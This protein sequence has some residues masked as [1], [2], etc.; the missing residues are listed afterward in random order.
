MLDSA[1]KSLSSFTFA[2]PTRKTLAPREK[3]IPEVFAT[4]CWFNELQ[5]HLGVSTVVAVQQ[6]A[7]P[8]TPERAAALSRRWRAY[9][10]GEQRPS[11]STVTLA[12]RIPCNAKAILHSP[13]WDALRMDK[14]PDPIARTLLG[15]TC[16][17]GDHLLNWMLDKGRPTLHPGTVQK[18]CQAIVARVDLDGLAILTICMRLAGQRSVSRLA[19]TFYWHATNCLLMLGGWLCAHGIAQSLADFYETILLPRYCHPLKFAR[20]SSHHYLDTVRALGRALAAAG[21]EC[22]GR[23]SEENAVAIMLKIR[24]SRL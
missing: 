2:S 9:K 8:T 17:D 15:T 12:E 3:L 16:A 10:S 21:E 23:L 1:Q 6:A 24:Q 4:I 20:F 22:H 7:E 19:L 14:T 13:L 18:R 5:L 11:P